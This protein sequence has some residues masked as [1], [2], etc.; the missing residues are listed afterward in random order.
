M[1]SQKLLVDIGVD[2]FASENQLAVAQIHKIYHSAG[3]ISLR[4]FAVGQVHVII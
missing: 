2:M 3:I 4:P 1:L